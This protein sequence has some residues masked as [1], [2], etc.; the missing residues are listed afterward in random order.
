MAIEPDDMGLDRIRVR[1]SV[2]VDRH[3]RGSGLAAL[4]VLARCGSRAGLGDKAGRHSVVVK[5]RET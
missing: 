3:R 1:G 4:D 5:R 2:A